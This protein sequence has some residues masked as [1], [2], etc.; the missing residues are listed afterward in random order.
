[1]LHCIAAA[2]ADLQQTNIRI[3]TKP[4]ILLRPELGLLYRCNCVRKA[5]END[6][7]AG[8]LSSD[9]DLQFEHGRGDG[10]PQPS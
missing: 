5:N 2:L 3:V 9:P 7:L 1:M 8:S 10:K 6:S 4:I